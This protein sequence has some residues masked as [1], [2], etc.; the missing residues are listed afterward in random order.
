[1]SQ[2]QQYALV[3]RWWLEAL[4]AQGPSKPDYWS[5]C[6]QCE[7]AT[8]NAQDALDAPPPESVLTDEEI[9][10]IIQDQGP[11]NESGLARAIERAVLTRLTE[12][13]E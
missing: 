9:R 6:D 8:G 11:D 1:M 5:A 13:A 7:R 2:R 10:Q 12:S 3:P 4:A